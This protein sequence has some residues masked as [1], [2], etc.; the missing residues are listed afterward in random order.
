MAK[1]LTQDQM[2]AVKVFNPHEFCCF[3]Y[4]V[5]YSSDTWHGGWFLETP[6]LGRAR[7][8]T[9]RRGKETPETLQANLLPVM[10][11][12]GIPWPGE[13]IKFMGVWMDKSFYDKR[14]AELV[15]EYKAYSKMARI[16]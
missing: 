5:W 8:P 15:A 16:D 10:T 13:W 12:R 11:Q 2:R 14:M 6:G 3:G 4:Y 7:I 9:M 1:K